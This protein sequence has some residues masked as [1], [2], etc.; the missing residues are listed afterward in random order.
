M[1]ELADVNA[2]SVLLKSPALAP[3]MS[4]TISKNKTGLGS[5]VGVN[6]TVAQLCK[7]IRE[8]SGIIQRYFF[9]TMKGN[10]ANA[11]TFE[12]SETSAA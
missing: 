10:A 12:V 2:S 4:V 6:R 9:V 5:L 1:P 11:Y 7:Q 3:V 8:H